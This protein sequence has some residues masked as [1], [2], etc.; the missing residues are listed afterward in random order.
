MLLAQWKQQRETLKQTDRQTDLARDVNA[1]LIE[2][3][4]DNGILFLLIA[5][6]T[7]NVIQRVVDYRQNAI[8]S[9]KHSSSTQSTD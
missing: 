7:E 6:L 2:D 8:H 9:D 1:D 4:R 3:L 5:G